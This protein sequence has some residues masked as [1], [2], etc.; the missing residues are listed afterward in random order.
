MLVLFILFVFDSHF[1]YES[2]RKKS[3]FSHQF[4]DTLLFS[5]RTTIAL[6]IHSVFSEAQ[7][8]A[9]EFLVPEVTGSNTA[10][11]LVA[12][13]KPYHVYRNHRWYGMK[14]F[15]KQTAYRLRSSYRY[16]QVITISNG[17][18]NAFILPNYK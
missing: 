1:K 11:K 15:F 5:D 8:S 6:K 2:H 12:T 17:R 13:I 7:W 16:E 3:L 18:Y 10:K 9:L 14:H 4:S